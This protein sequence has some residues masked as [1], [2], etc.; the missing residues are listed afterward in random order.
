MKVHIVKFIQVKACQKSS[1]HI[2]LTIR[3]SYIFRKLSFQNYW[4]FTTIK[5]QIMVFTQ[6]TEFITIEE[7]PK[8]LPFENL[9][10]FSFSAKRSD[11]FQFG[12]FQALT[13][14]RKNKI[15]LSS[16]SP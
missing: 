11:S 4:K 7:Y 10:F 9:T 15:S 6:H 8:N 16:E 2:S 13:S 1:S 14:I 5:T 3:A 12:H